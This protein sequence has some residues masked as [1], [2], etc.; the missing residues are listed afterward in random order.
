M[1]LLNNVHLA[2]FRDDSQLRMIRGCLGLVTA[3][4]MSRRLGGRDLNR[5]SW[6]VKR[7]S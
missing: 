4:L 3:V 6:L 1:V 2:S 7:P 5:I